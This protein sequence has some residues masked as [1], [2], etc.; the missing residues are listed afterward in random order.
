MVLLSLLLAACSAAGNSG[1]SSEK[2]AE[3]RNLR[4]E[5]ISSGAP[6][7]GPQRQRV[8]V[9]PSAQALSRELGVEIPNSGE[10]IY[11]ISYW[12]MKPTGG[13]SLAVESARLEGKLVTVRLRLKEP[14]PDAMVTQA[15]TYPYAAAV[16]Q[17]V[18]LRGKEFSFVDQHGRKLGWPVRKMSG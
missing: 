8:V 6:G 1:G 18:S 17:D 11:L 9:A 2:P 10:G 16:V 13:Y 15:L 5:R 7:Q 3:P 12:G 4:V 14:P